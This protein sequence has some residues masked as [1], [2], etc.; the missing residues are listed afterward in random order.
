MK[1]NLKKLAKAPVNKGYVKNSSTLVTVLFVIGGALYN[2]TNG[3]GTAIT[4][5]LALG[6]MIVQKLLIN[7]T[8]RDFQDMYHAK[9]MYKKTN[10]K[11]YLLFI[12]SCAN[13]MLK[14]T[15]VLTVKAKKEVEELKDYAVK[16]KGNCAG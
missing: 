8:D 7:Q 14:E 9:E 16:H 12:N 5:I 1:I 6:V 3:Y 2:I 11:N 15:K 13:R 10:D 4:L